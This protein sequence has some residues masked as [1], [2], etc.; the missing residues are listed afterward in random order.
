MSVF[1]K[2]GFAQVAQ[3]HISLDRTVFKGLQQELINSIRKLIIY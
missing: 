1:G 2:K 3:V